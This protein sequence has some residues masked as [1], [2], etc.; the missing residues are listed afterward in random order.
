[1]LQL[2]MLLLHRKKNKIAE[3]QAKIK[4]LEEETTIKNQQQAKLDRAD[5]DE[6]IGSKPRQLEGMRCTRGCKC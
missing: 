4:K 1:M 5:I 2:I 6:K 3:I